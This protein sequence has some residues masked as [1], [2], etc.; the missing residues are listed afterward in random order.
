LDAV[1]GSDRD[2]AKLAGD[3]AGNPA[4]LRRWLSPST[5]SIVL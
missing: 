5:I 3:P 4:H 1:G 2:K